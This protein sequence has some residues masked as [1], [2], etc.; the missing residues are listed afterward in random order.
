MLLSPALRGSKGVGEPPLAM[1]FTAFFAL[2]KAIA[3]ARADNGLTGP[4]NLIS[5][6]T[7]ERIRVACG[8]PL[9]AIAEKGAEQKEGEKSFFV[10]IF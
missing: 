1:G 7:C 10:S 2:K 4:W 5:P 8:D 6:A 3:A 9:L